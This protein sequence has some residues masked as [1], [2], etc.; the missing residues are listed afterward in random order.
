MSAHYVGLS[1]LAIL[2]TTSLLFHEAHG[3]LTARILEW[4]AIKKQR[5]A[6]TYAD[7]SPSGQSCIFFQ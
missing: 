4:F 5:Q 6:K 3:V 7:K 2:L 1:V